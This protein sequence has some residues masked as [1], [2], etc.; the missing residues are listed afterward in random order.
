MKFVRVA[1]LLALAA[2]LTACPRKPEG[3]PTATFTVNPAYGPKPLVVNFTDTSDPG[4]APITSWAW[5]FG[6][7]STATDQN[8]AHTYTKNGVFDVSL[9]VTNAKGSDSTIT[10]GAVAVGNVWAAS[11]GFTGDDKAVAVAEASGDVLILSTVTQDGFD[12]TDMMLERRNGSGQLV[13][14]QFYGGDKDETAGGVVYDAGDIYICG[15]TKSFG[16][17]GT[18]A[19]VIRAD[20]TGN[21]VWSETYGTIADDTAEKIVVSDDG[22]V[23]AGATKPTGRATFDFYLFKIDSEGTQD[24]SKSYGDAAKA[25]QCHGLRIATDGGFILSGEQYNTSADFFVVRTDDAGKQLWTATGSSTSGADRAFD[26]FQQGDNYYIF[27]SGYSDTVTGYDVMMMKLDKDGKVLSK[28]FVGG[29]GAEYGYGVHA[30]GSNFI[31]AGSTTSSTAGGRDVYIVSVKTDGTKAWSKIIGGAQ[32]DIGNAITAV[33][34]DYVVA[35]STKSWGKGGSDTY[36]LRAN[37][38]GFAPAEPNP[39]L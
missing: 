19:Y 32:D 5:D 24:W 8:P 28:S 20:S 36:I 13:W 17:G 11:S 21:E 27:G 16:L 7:D 3:A 15:T 38:A 9:T 23:I 33:G 22:Y 1:L 2:G 29:G 18:D 34:G 14:R 35:G 10:V 12:N 4:D 26:G 31:V 30:T 6:D 39:A 25:E 37:T